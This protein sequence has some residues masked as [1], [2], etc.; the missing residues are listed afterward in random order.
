MALIESGKDAG[1]FNSKKTPQYMGALKWGLM[2]VSLGVGA[3]IGSFID[4]WRNHD[5]PFVTIPL[6][7]ASGGLGLLIYYSIARDREREDD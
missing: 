3:G 7:L 6:L 5:G 4:M 2:L 1:L